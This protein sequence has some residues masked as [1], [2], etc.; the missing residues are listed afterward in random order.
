MIASN[1]RQ[2]GMRALG[3]MVYGGLTLA[4]GY[5]A[6]TAF[7]Q[8]IM[9]SIEE[10]RQDHSV[11]SLIVVGGAAAAFGAGKR[12]MAEITGATEP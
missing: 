7:P 6:V 11:A 4:F 1:I 9:D 2:Q 8:A 12:C 3:S 10:N 5:V